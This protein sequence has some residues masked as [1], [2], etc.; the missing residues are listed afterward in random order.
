MLEFSIWDVQH[1]HATYIRTPNGRHIAIDLGTGSYSTKHEFSPL[2]H[3]RNEY[4][5]Q[6]LDYVVITHPHRDHIDDIFE[7]DAMNPLTLRRAGHLSSEDILNGNQ[8]RDFAKINKYLEIDRR[9]NQPVVGTLGDTNVPANWGGVDISFFASPTCNTNNLNNH[10]IVTIFQYLGLKVVIPGDNERASWLDLLAN[11]QF[12]VASENA[13][14]LLA[15]HHGREAGF[16]AELMDHLRPRIVAISDGPEG[17]TS[18]TSR[19]GGKVLQ[20][21]GEGWRAFH[22]DGSWDTRL[23]VTTRCDGMIRIK[24]FQE[25]NG[26]RVLNVLLHDGTGANRV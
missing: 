19:Y 18:A 26:N 4:G 22:R 13:D 8:P 24:I 7:F 6:Q 20:H 14:V 5:V 21:R 15:P 3:L 9:Y 16:C 2:R 11:P 25:T 10:S 17:G 1:G 12:C 23:C